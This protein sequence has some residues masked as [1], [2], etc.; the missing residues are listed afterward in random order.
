MDILTRIF[1]LVMIVSVLQVEL[2]A[3]IYPFLP[4]ASAFDSQSPTRSS[5]T[6]LHLRSA[7]HG[8]THPQ[9]KHNFLRSAGDGVGAHLKNE[10]MA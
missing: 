5:R 2:S 10:Q 6:Q 4:G 3:D 9:I 1:H 8:L 7:H